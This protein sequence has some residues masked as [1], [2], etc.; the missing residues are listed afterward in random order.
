M[1]LT[2]S[3]AANWASILSIPLSLALWF[4]TREKFAKFWER[5][6]KLIFS[7]FAV[8][9]V[10]TFWLGG[11]LNWLSHQVTWPVWALVL[12]ALLVPTVALLALRA[13]SLRQNQW[14]LQ[15]WA[16]YRSDHIFGVKWSW[17]YD[18][19]GISHI[20]GFC[21][22]CDMRL[23]YSEER[24]DGQPPDMFEPA[25][26]TVF[27]CEKCGARSE[28]VPGYFSHVLGR[29][30]REIDRRIRTEEWKKQRPDLLS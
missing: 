13:V 26:C 12:L 10:V 17:R 19:S 25:D 7:A 2:I 20:T 11:W 5:W 1:N 6:L 24:L 8:L 4:Y 18:T 28:R 16:G 22:R 14:V 30:E 23:V 27:V 3:N 29:V 15:E 9:I 21:P